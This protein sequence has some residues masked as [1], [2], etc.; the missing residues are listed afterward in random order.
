[1]RVSCRKTGGIAGLKISADIDFEKLSSSEQKEFMNL[2]E[3]AK[4]FEQPSKPDGKAM[5][6][7]N[8]YEI[9]IEDNGKK[10]SFMTNDA[11]AS[12][13]LMDLIDWLFDAA[14]DQ[15]PSPRS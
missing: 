14:R 10:N 12:E 11:S 4:L 5:P 15:K 8:Q 2:V 7:Q 13:E 6:D 1:M 3:R 9:T